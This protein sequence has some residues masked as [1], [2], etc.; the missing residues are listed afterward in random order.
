MHNGTLRTVE[1]KTAQPIGKPVTLK[2]GLL[3]PVDG[4]K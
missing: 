1:T 3:R 4:R 2:R